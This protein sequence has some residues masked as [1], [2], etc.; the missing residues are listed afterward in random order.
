MYLKIYKKHV[1]LFF[2]GA[3]SRMPFLRVDSYEPMVAIGEP[4]EPKI[5][6]YAGSEGQCR[7]G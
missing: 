6:S 2:L 4:N 7:I 5:C 3:L 1:S